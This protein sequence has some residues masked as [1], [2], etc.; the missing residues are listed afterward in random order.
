MPR[1]M[2]VY[3]LAGWATFLAG[4]MLKILGRNVGVALP[5]PGGLF[6]TAF[7]CCSSQKAFP[8]GRAATTKN[9]PATSRPP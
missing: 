7:W 3:G 5:I 2:A 6:K 4:A 9:W 1:L 8:R